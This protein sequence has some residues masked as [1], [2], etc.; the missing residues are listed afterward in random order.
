MKEIILLEE[1]SKKCLHS[2][3]LLKDI[4]H[5]IHIVFAAQFVSMQLKG[6]HKMMLTMIQ[7]KLP[8]LLNLIWIF[9]FSS[10]LDLFSLFNV[11]DNISH[12]IWHIYY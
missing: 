4:F 10:P 1:I 8:N 11:S 7:E 6:E 3:F 5:G 9:N 2:V 12:I